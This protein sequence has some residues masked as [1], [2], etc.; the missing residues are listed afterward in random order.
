MATPEAPRRLR[1]AALQRLHPVSRRR[2]AYQ[3]AVRLAMRLGLDG[4]VSRRV[5]DPL[6]HLVE[7]GLRRRLPA[8]GSMLDRPDIVAAV[9]WPP[10]TGR[11]RVYLHLFECRPGNEYRPVGFAKVSL[12]DA[13]DT[14]LD[15][16]ASILIEVSR[17]HSGTMHVPTVLGRT[18]IDGHLVVVTEPLPQDA[19]PIPERL[20]AFPADC[21]ESFAGTLRPVTGDGLST[22]S[23][24][25]AYRRCL[26]DHGD[27]FHRNLQELAAD[28]C[29][30]R[31]A[32]GDFGPSN[33]F[34]TPT[35]LWVLDW[36]H[37]ATDAPV[38][39]D[40]ITF[41]VGVNAR[42]IAADPVAALRDFHRRRLRRADTATRRD[43]LLALAFRAAVGGR[44]AQ[45]FIR[46]WDTLS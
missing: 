33:I 23:W 24:W 41:D 3:H 27:V 28:G 31:R 32:H 44:D 14:L 43:I 13:N 22:L 42:R 35:G 4:L 29:A 15:R 34:E 20:D 46:H 19:A 1:L 26:G 16:E 17:S 18:T 9:F 45:L 7:G 36:E 40:E 12:D 39:A 8:L 25:A 2:R 11:G 5:T 38:L 37:S 6:G 10:E 30:V 21:V